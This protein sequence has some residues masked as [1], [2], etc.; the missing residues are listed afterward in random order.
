MYPGTFDH[1]SA[2]A[3][4]AEK[5]AEECERGMN[6]SESRAQKDEEKTEILEIRLKEA[7]HIAQDADCKY[8]EVAGKLVIINDSGHCR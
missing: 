2:E 4:E 8:E 7:K 5:A 3:G 1:S 6:V